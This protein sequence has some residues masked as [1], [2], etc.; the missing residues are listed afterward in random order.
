[1]QNNNHKFMFLTGNNWQTVVLLMVVCLIPVIYKEV[2]SIDGVSVS[3]IASSVL[4]TLPWCFLVAC[5]KKKWVFA[6]VSSILMM[7]SFFETIMV[8][9]Y[10]NYVIAGNI[11][12]A[13][14]TTS[15]EGTG[16]V[17][18]SLHALTWTLPVFIAFGLSLC[19]F[20]KPK[21]LKANLCGA[22][23]F[24]V[25]TVGFLTYQLKVR[26]W[27][28]ITTKFY[29]EQNVLSRPP[30]NFWFQIYNAIEQQRMRSYIKKSNNMTFSATR[31]LEMNRESYVL[32]IGESLRYDNLSLAGY[33]RNTTPLLGSLEDLTLFSDYYSSANLTMFSVPQIITRATADNF[34]LNYKEKSI[35]KPFQECGFKAFVICAG[36]LLCEKSSSYLI[37]GCDGVF[38]FGADGDAKIAGVVDSLVAIY[39]KIFFVIQFKGNHGPY[40]NF[41]QEHNAYRPN[42]VYD[43]V[44]WTNHE[45]MV[46]AYDNTVLFTDYNVYHII[47]AIDKPGYQSAL[48]MVSDH[49]ADYDTGVSDHGGNCNPRKAE[50]HVPL[51]VWNS[52]V[53]G[54]KYPQKK[55]HLLSNKN[56]PVNSDNIFYSVCDMA[57]ITIDKKYSKPEWSV[58]VK[59]LKP[60][61]R[62][63]LVP[64]GKNYIIV[65]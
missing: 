41:G 32:V 65:E 2:F 50:Y 63:L 20:Q 19:F 27:G 37:D 52:K 64:D 58:F 28:D 33:H 54:E 31:P 6:V 39:P 15:D 36:N 51:I 43:K 4:Y 47:K 22:G 7:V 34:M 1:M 60:H 44:P 16:F 18:S 24:A 3:R 23:L 13:L 53:W 49:G 9:L 40:N 61:E 12:A 45:A 59:N 25:L 55:A 10:K 35:I 62:K 46:N 17:M 8:V 38:A 21:R 5:I 29:V 57:D 26:F 56:K 30:Y 14:T 42:P 48:L 11:I